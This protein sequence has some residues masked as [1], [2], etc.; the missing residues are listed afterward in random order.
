MFDERYYLM[1]VNKLMVRLRTA[2]LGHNTPLTAIL[3]EKLQT[4]PL[5]KQAEQLAEQVLFALVR[6]LPGKTHTPSELRR[7]RSWLQG[8]ARY[9][10]K[11]C[12]R[13]DHTFAGWKKLLELSRG[14]RSII[15]AD[16]DDPA[17]KEL[18]ESDPPE[19]LNEFDLAVLWLL[20]IFVLT[21]SPK[22]LYR[23]LTDISST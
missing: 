23:Q 3:P 7:C 8:T 9:L 21:E 13:S 12:P 5:D 1:K 14:L 17:A 6:A 4:A 18:K 16:Y 22:A 10:L 11:K 15:F 19:L 2:C 20:N